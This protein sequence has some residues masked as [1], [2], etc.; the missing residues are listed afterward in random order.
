MMKAVSRKE[1]SA[2]VVVTVMEEGSQA[3]MEDSKVDMAALLAEQHLNTLVIEN[4]EEL[5]NC[6][7][8]LRV[9]IKEKEL[10]RSKM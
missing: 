7:I 6:K 8:T 1:F 2:R 4:S 5:P 3:M 9:H 10:D